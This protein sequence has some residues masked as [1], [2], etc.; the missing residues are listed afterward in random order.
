M[1]ASWDVVI[2]GAGS[3][4]MAAAEGA[5]RQ[6]PAARILLLD[7][8][9]EAPYRRTQLSKHIASGFTA[10]QFSLLDTG[11][12][13][14]N[15]TE[16]RVGQAVEALDCRA[17][18]LQLSGGDS[19]RYNRLVLATGAAPIYPRIVRP[20]E[21][22]SFFVLRT[23]RDAQRLVDALASVRTVLIDGM[24]VL[25]IEVANQLVR[26]RKKPTLVGA[27]AQLMPRQLSTR[28]A[29]IMEEVLLRSKVKLLFQNEI[30]SFEKNAKGGHD[31]AMLKNSDVFDMVVLCIGVQP[32]IELAARAGLHTDSGIIVD[33]ELRTSDPAVFAAGDVAQHPDGSISYLWHAAEYQGGIAGCNAAGGNSRNDRRAFRLKTQVFDTFVFSMNLPREALHHRVEEVESGE[34]YQAFYFLDD[35]LDG[36]VALNDEPRSDLYSQAV[37]ERWEFDRV[38]DT[39][40]I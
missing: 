12:A 19:V 6:N 7:E 22:G 26:M 2:V 21:A 31:V 8:E 40:M 23:L 30:L 29:E 17:R 14:Q 38:A 34:V 1:E 27:T 15:E 13:E 9:H 36:V 4:G 3:A 20:R 25:A 16:L 32:R 39:L 33:E 35:R 5:H 28:A 11:W 24:G 37:V 10:D 18:E